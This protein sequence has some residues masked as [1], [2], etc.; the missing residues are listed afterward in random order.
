MKLLADTL[1]KLASSWPC[2]V[3][4]TPH[5]G[6]CGNSYLKVN[7][8]RLPAHR[9]DKQL[10]ASCFFVSE[11]TFR[12]FTT[13]K[14]VEPQYMDPQEIWQST[15]T[16]NTKMPRSFFGETF[17]RR[18]QDVLPRANSHSKKRASESDLQISTR[19]L[20]NANSIL[21]HFG[22]GL[23]SSRSL[24]KF[25]VALVGPSPSL[26]QKNGGKWA[27]HRCAGKVGQGV[28]DITVI[29]ATNLEG[30]RCSRYT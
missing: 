10:H 25:Q 11:N 28:D 6:R 29:V 1:P 9:L 26:A 2:Q 18:L 22:Y 13:W 19:I 12:W 23:N 14:H 30:G 5:W 17:R 20:T 16:K 27:P 3:G 7:A 24:G 15:S 4:W 8:S 21:L